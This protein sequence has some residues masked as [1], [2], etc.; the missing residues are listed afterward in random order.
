MFNL[1]DYENMYYENLSKPDNTGSDD[2]YFTI[3]YLYMV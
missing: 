3:N 1:I 2:S